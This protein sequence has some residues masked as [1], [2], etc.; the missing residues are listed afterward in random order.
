MIA[1]NHPLWRD[2][3]SLVELDCGLQ[4]HLYRKPNLQRRHALLAVDYGAV[5]DWLADGRGAARRAPRGV[6][7]FIEHCLF[8]KADGDIT[9]RFNALGAEVDAHTTFT[10][11]GFSF[12]ATDGFEEGLSLLL[13]LVLTP[14][15]SQAVLER[16]RDVILRELDL[17]ADHVE[18]V[19]FGAALEALY[20]HAA[21][22]ADIAGTADSLMQ[23]DLAVLEAAYRTFYH[24]R[25]MGLFVTGD[26][27][28][29]RVVERVSRSLDGRAWSALTPGPR[30]FT[31]ATS[32]RSRRRLATALP[33]L[34]V[35]LAAPR[36]SEVGG[37]LLRRELCLDLALDILFGP[38]SSFYAR[39][40]EAG[41]VDDE[42]FGY[43]IYCEPA[44]AFCLVGGDTPDPARLEAEVTERIAAARDGDLIERHLE[45]S[46]RRAWGQLVCQYDDVAA[47][48]AMTHSAVSRG[49]PPFGY[50]A[51]HEGLEAGEVAACVEGWLVAAHRGVA[52]VLSTETGDGEA[53]T[54]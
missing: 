45:R 18:W 25:R 6:A 53:P 26:V 36:A 24:P 2:E 30:P 1:L 28:L 13:E 19:A 32:G 38:A 10:S 37:D 11:T 14:H 41:L 20:P 7:H 27:D 22:G 47:C 5:D 15:F 3:L 52:E 40:Y 8:E 23:T 9:G 35:G 29:E 17:Y 48:A 43:E 21:I 39:H 4:V 34:L 46:R 51:A 12:T 42:T 54:Q 49:C 50:F 33:R 16:E 31:A 44:F